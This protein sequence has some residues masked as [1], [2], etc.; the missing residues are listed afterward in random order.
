MHIMCQRKRSKERTCPS[1]WIINLVRSSEAS[2]G[3]F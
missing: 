1:A 3:A 2:P